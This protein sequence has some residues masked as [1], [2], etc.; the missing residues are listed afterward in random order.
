[1]LRAFK[2]DVR[3]RFVELCAGLISRS[4]E[5]QGVLDEIARRVRVRRDTSTTFAAL[6]EAHNGAAYLAPADLSRTPLTIR[7]V[8]VIGSCLAEE[9]V[10]DIACPTDFILVNNLSGLPERPPL[11]ASDYDV[12]IVQLPLR[13]PFYDG[14]VWNLPFGDLA[15]HE[16][17]FDEARTRLRG[18]LELSLSWNRRY[19]LLTFVAN[20]IVPQQNPMGRLLPRYDLRNPVYFVERLNAA[21]E[22]ELAGYEN[23]HLL[24]ID[25]IAAVCGR[26]FLQDDAINA[27]GHG[28]LWGNDPHVALDAL[29]IEPFPSVAEHYEFVDRRRFFAL[30]WNQVVAM[31]RTLRRQDEVKLAIVD[32]DD[33]LWRGVAAEGVAVENELIEGWPIGLIE[34]LAYLKKRGVLLAIVS[35]NEES[36]VVELWDRIMRGR[37]RLGDFAVR[38]INW[39][40]KAENV[41]GVLAVV[42]VLPKNVLFIDDNPAER[43]AVAAAFPDIRTLGAHPLYL[44]RILLWS[45][46]TQVASVTGESQRRTE[47]VQSQVL[48]ERE[49]TQFSREEFL[50]SLELE[51]EVFE[52][53]ER[54]DPRFERLLELINKTNQF[55]TTGRRRTREEFFSGAA[56]GPRLFGFRASDRFS[57]YG[58]IGA[59][60]TR[61]ACLE[62]FVMSCRV[63]GLDVETAVLTQLIATLR[64]AGSPEI[65][66]V[67]GETDANFPCRDLYQRHNFTPAP[68]V[69]PSLSRD[70]PNPQTWSLSVAEAPGTT[71][72]VQ[73]GPGPLRNG[74][75][76]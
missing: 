34:A 28:S 45:S 60:V 14:L 32:L 37:F 48:R 54:A 33:T 2:R 9:W 31:L 1:M 7:R 43:A 4:K 3:R 67:L 51:V 40:P 38:E 70:S 10:A 22:A 63:I 6:R 24:D 26:R 56:T 41:A 20:F 75:G 61:E 15:A 35:K 53:T 21:L 69:I 57:D 47:L 27:I 62:Q 25:A 5:P 68:V 50:A 74:A 29:R 76:P 11:P 30:G 19:G 13:G 39:R 42:N 17:A 23:V 73:G 8:L 65:T 16:R 66:A 12:Q 64:T 49:R 71:K 55:N 72:V 36:R 44:R 52:V 59:V 18:A 46:E 58:T